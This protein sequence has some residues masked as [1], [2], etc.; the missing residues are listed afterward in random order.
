MTFVVLAKELWDNDL[1]RGNECDSVGEKNVVV[2]RTEMNV[3][4]SNERL[5]DCK[6]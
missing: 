1:Q 6:R 3:L 5:G 2:K 4:L